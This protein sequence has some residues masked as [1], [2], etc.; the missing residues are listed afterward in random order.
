MLREV[1]WR[2]Q[3]DVDLTGADPDRTR[4]RKLAHAAPVDRYLGALR[5]ADDLDAGEVILNGHEGVLEGRSVFGQPR[6]TRRAKRFGDM[7]LGILP[8]TEGLL[9]QT[10]LARRPRSVDVIVRLLKL[11]R[12]A[13]VVVGLA[14]LD[15]MPDQLLGAVRSLGAQ[16]PRPRRQGDHDPETNDPHTSVE[17]ATPHENKRQAR[18]VRRHCREAAARLQGG[19]VSNRVEKGNGAFFRLSNNPLGQP[20]RHHAGQ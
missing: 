3:V 16:R 9:G 11:A 5:V 18:C 1:A 4:E 6:I 17:H 7:A 20:A 13:L 2:A 12:G 15:A 10:Q 8:A 14:K 19:R